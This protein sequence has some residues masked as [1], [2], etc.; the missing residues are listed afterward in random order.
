MTTKIRRIENVYIRA[1]TRGRNSHYGNPSYTL[2]TSEGDYRTQKDASLNY[3]IT[4]YTN[5]RRPETF[6]IGDNVPP[7]TLI[8]TPSGRVWSI[9]KDGEALR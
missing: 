5:S 1:I 7:V 3:S 2:H 6:V 4:N 8:A 9:E